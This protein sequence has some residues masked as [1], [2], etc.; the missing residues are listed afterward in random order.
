MNKGSSKLANNNSQ[1]SKSPSNGDSN[2]ST[3]SASG[4]TPSASLLSTLLIKPSPIARLTKPW[5]PFIPKKETKEKNDD[6]F[7]SKNRPLAS[8]EFK[9]QLQA[10]VEYN[11]IRT[12]LRNALKEDKELNLFFQ[13]PFRLQSEDLIPK[14]LYPQ[15]DVAPVPFEQDPKFSPETTLRYEI[16]LKALNE[17]IARNKAVLD[18]EL[19]ILD[20]GVIGA[21]PAG[22]VGL[23]HLIHAKIKFNATVYEQREHFS[24][25]SQLIAYPALQIEKLLDEKAISEL[26]NSGGAYHM[27]S[28]QNDCCGFCAPTAVW[29]EVLKNYLLRSGVR[30]ESATMMP[31]KLASKVDLVISARGSHSPDAAMALNSKHSV[32]RQFGFIMQ[33]IHRAHPP[34]LKPIKDMI[35]WERQEDAGQGFPI[36]TFNSVSHTFARRRDMYFIVVKEPS[37]D[38]V[39]TG[40]DID[41]TPI[42]PNKLIEIL[43]KQIHRFKRKS[44]LTEEKSEQLVIQKE[45]ER[46]HQLQKTLKMGD[47]IIFSECGVI[48]RRDGTFD[49]RCL[50]VFHPDFEILTD[51]FVK[52]P[53]VLAKPIEEKPLIQSEQTR[54]TELARLGDEVAT[55]HWAT[56]RGFYG[57]VWEGK[58][59][60]LLCQGIQYAKKLE[61]LVGQNDNLSSKAI[62][63][64]ADAIRHCSRR[65]YDLSVSDIAHQI[66]MVGMVMDILPRYTDIDPKAP[67]TTT[68]PNFAQFTF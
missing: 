18:G 45:I 34:L 50:E 6:K 39:S 11:A 52:H 38:E 53:R 21:G 13:R 17:I 15:P 66:A 51:K 29:Q 44:E 43:E 48:V 1:D 8:P 25:L 2:C 54:K 65:L 10:A 67:D 42:L 24:R 63:A 14:S 49:K 60:V 56:G 12:K 5:S 22:L 37:D 41:W 59:L 55:P 31:E 7:E 30:F 23:V 36:A 47:L 35:P 28:M 3:P 32:G 33:T 40:S 27:R 64:D 68:P 19:S 20:I 4:S 26:V 62:Q 9:A 16:E 46:I 57:P 58:Q 61:H